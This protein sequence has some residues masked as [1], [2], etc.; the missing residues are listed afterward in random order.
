MS[1]G[2]YEAWVD[3]PD[4]GYSTRIRNIENGN[5]VVCGENTNNEEF[6]CGKEIIV[7]LETD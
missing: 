3:C 2:G 1:V 7:K 5:S 6:G 4:C